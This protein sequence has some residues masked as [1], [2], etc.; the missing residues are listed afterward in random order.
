MSATSRP[1]TPA[2]DLSGT[3]HRAQI[4]IA[5]AIQLGNLTD[6]PLRYPLEAIAASLD[7][8]YEFGHS[9]PS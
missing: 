1:T 8:R 5:R 4:G 2:P 7:E 9:N 3:I 6:D